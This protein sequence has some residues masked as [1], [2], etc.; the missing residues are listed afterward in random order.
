MWCTVREAGKVLHWKGALGPFY[1]S[2]HGAKKFDGIDGGM[3]AYP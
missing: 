1:T 3:E 2:G